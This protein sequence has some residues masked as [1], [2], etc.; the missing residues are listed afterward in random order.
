M[1]GVG[2]SFAGV[3]PALKLAWAFLTNTM[4]THDRAVVVEDALLACCR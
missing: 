4:G 2:G 1:A 3:R